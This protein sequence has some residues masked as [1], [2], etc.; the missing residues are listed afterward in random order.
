MKAGMMGISLKGRLLLLAHF[1]LWAA[2][3]TREYIY[4]HAKWFGR[5]PWQTVVGYSSLV[6]LGAAVLTA[7]AWVSIAMFRKRL[8]LSVAAFLLYIVVFAILLE[9]VSVPIE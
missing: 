6:V 4:G 8:A 1:G 5:A 7:C 3:F 9:R 2:L